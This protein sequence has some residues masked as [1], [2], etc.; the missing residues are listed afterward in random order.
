[1][2]DVCDWLMCLA[3]DGEIEGS[4]PHR[5]RKTSEEFLMTHLGNVV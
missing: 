4:N 5:N 1:M 3:V 2:H